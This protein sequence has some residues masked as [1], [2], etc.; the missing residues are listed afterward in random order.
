MD[1]PGLRVGGDHGDVRATYAAHRRDSDA[2]IVDCL[3]HLVLLGKVERRCYVQPALV[4]LARA[5]LFNQLIA[6]VED[7]V[8]GAGGDVGEELRLLRDFAR[9]IQVGELPF[10]AFSLLCGDVR[11]LGHEV[12]NKV[13]SLNECV[14]MGAKRREVAGRIR[15]GRENRRLRQVHVLGAALLRGVLTGDAMRVVSLTGAFDAVG[16]RA[17][18]DFV[19]VELEDLVLR[20]E[21]LKFYRKNE[22]FNLAG[23]RPLR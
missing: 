9:V 21:L 5:V 10:G 13:L 16:C 22:L 20:V 3:V 6:S 15:D 1:L 8:L 4:G 14:L 7:E 19:E 12:E 17:V 2:R 11:L 23:V 18:G